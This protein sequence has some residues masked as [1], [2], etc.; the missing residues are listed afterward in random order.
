MILSLYPHSLVDQAIR[1][2]PEHAKAR[3]NHDELNPWSQR[4]VTLQ[5]K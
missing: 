2:A 3:L 1:T 4:K 5:D